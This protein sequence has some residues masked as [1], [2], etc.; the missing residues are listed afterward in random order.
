MKQTLLGAIIFGFT[1]ISTPACS[2]DTQAAA[3]TASETY[4]PGMGEIMASTQ[5]RHA[6]LW[7][8]GRAHNWELASYEVDEIEEG[9]ADAVKYHPIFKKDAPVSAMLDKYTRPPLQD[10]RRAIESKDSREFRHAF[11]RLTAACNG[12]HEAAGQG[13]IVI[14]RPAGPA[15]GNQEFAAKAR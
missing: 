15:F 2:S 14:R 1:A 4:V 5:M 9:L 10:L 6:K 3:H 7:F 11:D 12:C 13:F 8:A